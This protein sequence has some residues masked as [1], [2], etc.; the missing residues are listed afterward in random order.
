MT[1]DMKSSKYARGYVIQR[2][3][4]KYDI[5]KLN[6]KWPQINFG[7]KNEFVCA[8][9]PRN[10]VINFKKDNYFCFILGNIVD[11]KNWTQNL[12]TIAESV[13]E[14]IDNKTSLYE[15]VDYLAGRYILIYGSNSEVYLLQDACGMRTCYYSDALIA[16]HYNII[17][18]LQAKEPHFFWEK[19][20]N[21]SKK[22]W[23]LPGDITPWEGV[24]TL[25]PN[26]ELNLDSFTVKRFYPRK[27]HEILNPIS[28]VQEFS[29][30]LNK[31]AELLS[32]KYKLF[33]SLTG[34]VDSRVTLS[35][36]K[37]IKSD[38]LFYTYNNG[39]KRDGNDL[40]NKISKYLCS[41]F[42]LKFVNIILNKKLPDG[43]REIYLENHYHE[44]VLHAIPEYIDLLPCEGGLHLRSNI[45][46]IVRHRDYFRPSENSSKALN[47]NTYGFYGLDKEEY[48][49]QLFDEFYERNEYNRIFNYEIGDIFYMEYRMGVWHSGGILLG[50]DIAFDTYCL[51]NCRRLIDIGMSI[52]K[53]LKDNNYLPNSIIKENWA[54]LF[55]SIPNT[56]IFAGDISLLENYSKDQ[57]EIINNHN[58]SDSVF[59]QRRKDSVEALIYSANSLKKIN[60]IYTMRFAPF[61]RS[62]TVRFS[63][64]CETNIKI[65]KNIRIKISIG[66]QIINCYDFEIFN[67][68]KF[69]EFQIPKKESFDLSLAF[70]ND[71]AIDYDSSLLIRINNFYTLY[72]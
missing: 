21:F 1:I 42:N 45:L 65:S 16:S 9:D 5:A 4:S 14:L 63:L 32:R 3:S 71:D 64:S 60:N 49:Q 34:G 17:G 22:P 68:I 40:D 35:A 47:R 29:Y 33:T 24:H 61:W 44:H 51:F 50:T 56:N 43:F 28:V 15:Y 13:C 36:L 58:L 31:Q 26:H 52:P 23:Y 2:T 12:L 10:A 55:A 6:I 72:H 66:D 19:Y 18:R 48:V 46:E 27:K 25:L 37:N 67:N 59:V 38:V 57:F 41:L 39:S 70:V 8:Y 54:E 7:I 30:S 69:I 53:Y 20:N 62:R 11:T